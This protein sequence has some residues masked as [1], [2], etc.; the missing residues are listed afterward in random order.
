MG[1]GEILTFP[2]IQGNCWM[3]RIPLEFQAAGK[4]VGHHSNPQLSRNSGEVLAGK[5]S[6]YGLRYRQSKKWGGMARN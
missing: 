3:V 2:K 1:L 6:T 4:G 5:N